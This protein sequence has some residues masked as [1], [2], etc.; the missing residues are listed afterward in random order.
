MLNAWTIHMHYISKSLYPS[1]NYDND[2]WT[3]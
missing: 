2:G 1:I 3:Y